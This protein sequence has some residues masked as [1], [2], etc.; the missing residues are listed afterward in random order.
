MFDGS[1]GI[2]PGRAP[3]V[4][5]LG[6]G[7]LKLVGADGR[8]ESYFIDGGFVQVKG[9]QVSVLTNAACPVSDISRAAAAKELEQARAEKASTDEDMNVLARKLERARK[10]VSL[11]QKD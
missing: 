7:E 3:L 10:M 2:Y 8:G 11:A 5:R 4:G 9:A 6:L 1:A